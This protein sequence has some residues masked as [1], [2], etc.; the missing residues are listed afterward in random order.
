MIRAKFAC[1]HEID[2]TGDEQHPRCPCG[3]DRLVGLIAR[4]PRF[5]GYALGPCAQYE[6][7]PAIPVELK[8]ESNG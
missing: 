4:P 7:L 6:Q 5:K 8:K 1:G 2:L 3:N